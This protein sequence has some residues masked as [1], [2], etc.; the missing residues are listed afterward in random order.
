LIDLK[1]K[2]LAKSKKVSFNDLKK[3]IGGY[4]IEAKSHQAVAAS[5]AQGKA[6]VGVG[7]KTV[8]QLYNLE[9]IHLANE[10]YDF[11]IPS[12]RAEKKSV[13]LFFNTLRSKEFKN[14]ILNK[15]PGLK[16]DSLTGKI[17]DEK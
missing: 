5:I 6:N 9:F 17:I 7:I 8:A 13:K 4:N 12:N 1:L 2:K 3:K 16:P 10:M 11:L 14:D 15:M